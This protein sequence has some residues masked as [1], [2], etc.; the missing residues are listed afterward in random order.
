MACNATKS[1]QDGDRGVRGRRRTVRESP[2]APLPSC[3]ACSLHSQPLTLTLLASIDEH[4]GRVARG[5]GACSPCFDCR[6]RHLRDALSLLVAQ[7]EPVRSAHCIRPACAASSCQHP[8]LP[9]SPRPLSA[10]DR[11]GFLPAIPLPSSFL[12]MLLHS[13]ASSGGSRKR[14]ATWAWGRRMRR[15]WPAAHPGL[16]RCRPH[17]HSL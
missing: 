16:R 7:Q 6:L 4:H 8:L 17:A 13:C 14:G 9:A 12:R 10:A 11:N 2:C 15:H 5:A 3:H 1:A